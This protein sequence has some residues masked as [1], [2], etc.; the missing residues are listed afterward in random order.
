[1]KVACVVGARPNF[2]KMAPI[3][4]AMRRHGDA[5]EPILIHTGQ[6]YDSSL[7]DAIFK[8]LDLPEPD[9]YLGVGSGTHAEQTARVMTAFE[10]VCRERGP[11][12]VLVVGDVNSTLAAAL[13][14]AKL[15][16]PLAHVEAG[17]RSGDRT[18][19]EEI[20]RIVTDTLSE[21]LFT[22]EPSAEEN[23][24]REG[25]A[26]GKIHFVGN[27]MIDSLLAN[28]EEALARAPWTDLG[29]G[30]N[31]YGVVTLHRPS[32]V[33]DRETLSGIVRALTDI[34]AELPLVFPVHPRARRALECSG[35]GELRSDGK[36]LAVDPMGY[37]D[38]LGLVAESRLVLTDSGGLQEETTVLGIPCL[39]VR[40]NTERPVTLSE[41]TNHL[42]GSDPDRIVEAARR[43]L[44][45]PRSPRTITCWDGKAAERIVAVLLNSC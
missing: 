4:K 7:S 3:L 10:K 1:M 25:V 40:D 43:A 30:T 21:F 24:R 36:I 27:V 39:T 12:L 15:L 26:P 31:A 9:H 44:G 11:E 18:M 32:H 38:F 6:H 33:D 16:V 37:L 29:L 5:F 13:V 35:L 23:L 41:G 17:L 20:N 22:T 42:V 28:H 8:D 19:P 45:Q 2:V 14:A 34:A